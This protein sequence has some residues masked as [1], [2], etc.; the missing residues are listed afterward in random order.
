MLTQ[1]E[2]ALLEYF[3][4]NA[5]KP[6]S[7]SAIAQ[8]V[9]RQAPI[10][11]DETN[12]VDVYVAYLRK[13]LDTAI[14]RPVLHTVRGVGYVLRARLVDSRE[15]RSPGE[16]SP[17]LLAVSVAGSPML[18]LDDRR[19]NLD[20]V[21]IVRRRVA[22]ETARDAVAAEVLDAAPDQARRQIDVR[23]Q[24]GSRRRVGHDLS[25]RGSACSTCRRSASADGFCAK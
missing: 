24:L 15:R 3:M 1:R 7:R 20:A 13:K 8:Q 18:L 25:S 16:I 12:I 9:W 11:I 23:D 21:R 5:G 10:D 17:G 19:R 2:F 4:R 6:L 22:G 14:E